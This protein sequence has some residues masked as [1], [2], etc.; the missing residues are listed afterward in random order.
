[1]GE[2]GLCQSLDRHLQIRA[3]PSAGIH[4]AQGTIGKIV[5]RIGG[6]LVTY[7]GTGTTR[8]VPVGLASSRPGFGRVGEVC[9][10]AASNAAPA[11]SGADGEAAESSSP[12][13][14]GVGGAPHEPRLACVAF[15]PFVVFVACAAFRCCGNDVLV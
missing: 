13:P 11:E 4:R 5:G 6:R 15:P 7:H 1:M 2:G 9:G 8:G 14:G 3:G 12:K 10:V